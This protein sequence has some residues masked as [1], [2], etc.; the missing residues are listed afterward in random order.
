MEDE[1]NQRR[2]GTVVGTG[3]PEKGMSKQHLAYGHVDMFYRP[4]RPSIK[5]IRTSLQVPVKPS[6][7]TQLS[8]S[9]FGSTRHSPASLQVALASHGFMVTL[10][11]AASHGG[12]VSSAISVGVSVLKPPGADAEGVVVATSGTPTSS[13]RVA[14]GE[15]EGPASGAVGSTDAVGSIVGTLATPSSPVGVCADVIKGAAD[16]SR[17]GR[18]SGM[19]RPRMLERREEGKAWTKKARR[20]VIV[21]A[22]SSFGP[23]SRLEE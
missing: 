3:Q 18:S 9:S 7:S 22:P 4:G 23:F 12:A 17:R 6:M 1:K 16:R 10:Q 2:K 13:S 19:S 15:E 8:P 21:L 14:P 20:G 11:A 5:K